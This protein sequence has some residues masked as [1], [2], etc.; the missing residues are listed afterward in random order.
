MKSLIL[1]VIFVVLTIFTSYSE[2][3]NGSFYVV[4]TSECRLISQSGPI[5]TNVIINGKTYMVGN[6][7][8]EMT[9]TN[10]TLFYFAGGPLV[11]ATSN[12]TF[13]INTFDQ[14]I[15]NLDAQPRKPEFG[16]HNINISLDRGE[17]FIIYPNTNENSSFVIN[18]PFTSYEL[19]GGKYSIRISDKSAVV[20][21]Y[22]GF[23]NIHG[24]KKLDKA[25]KG[26]LSIAIPFSDPLSGVNDKI[27]TSVKPLK[28][29]ENDRF[30]SP[31]VNI[32]KQIS[33]VQFFVIAG[34]IIGVW[35]N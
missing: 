13:T 1:S 15:N 24:D 9:I 4:G 20:Y 33:D 35:V 32:D 8:L 7:L 10:K 5:A 31:I 16:S 19:R 14:E 25:E 27:I 22:D 29:E 28:Q 23:M 26:K 3:T 6:S 11:C 12:S 34:R 17:Y 21:V 18:T 2:M 30:S